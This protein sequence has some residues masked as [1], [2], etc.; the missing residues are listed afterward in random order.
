[1]HMPRSRSGVAGRRLSLARYSYADA[2]E[3]ATMAAAAEEEK[4]EEMRTLRQG[5]AFCVG[6]AEE[7]RRRRSTVR[8]LGLP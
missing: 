7:L 6:E 1:M 5:I 2:E 4:K 8:G 3:V